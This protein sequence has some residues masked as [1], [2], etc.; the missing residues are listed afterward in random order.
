MRL[1]IWWTP[2]IPGHAFQ[3]EVESV[4]EG[5]A[6]LNALVDYTRYWEGR[7]ALT[8]YAA[9]AGGLQAYEE[10]EWYDAEVVIGDEAE[11]DY[12]AVSV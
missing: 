6:L 9:D 12:V 3:R 11:W 7:D 1:R 5:H 8:N 10:G 2:A 4:K